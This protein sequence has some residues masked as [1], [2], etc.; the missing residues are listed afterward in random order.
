MSPELRG[1]FK[2]QAEHNST[3]SIAS[4]PKRVAGVV[5]EAYFAPKPWE[6]D[7]NIYRKIGIRTF[8]RFI[9]SGDPAIRFV[10][11][12]LKLPYIPFYSLPEPNLD[13]AKRFELSTRVFES[14]HVAGVAVG[15]A[16]IAGLD[17]PL[18]GPHFSGDI[19]VNGAGIAANFYAAML[20]RYNRARIYNLVKRDKQIKEKIYSELTS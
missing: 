1:G 20:Q 3:Q 7:G 16:I 15:I 6:G 5:A 11:K 19:Y 2:P 12:K 9:P 18:S 8:R 13:K 10:R 17:V 4:L 14:V